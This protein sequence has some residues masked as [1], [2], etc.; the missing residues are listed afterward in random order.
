MPDPPASRPIWWR[1]LTEGVHDLSRLV[2]P[3]ECPGCGEWDVP[4]CDA[5][6]AVLDGPPVRCEEDVP[7][8]D[9]MDGLAPLPVWALASYAGPARGLVLG[10]KDRGRVDLTGLMVEAVH[11]VGAEVAP[12]LVGAVLGPGG[13]R[14]LVVPVPTTAA[15]R[16]RRGADLVRRLA[17]GLVDGLCQGGLDAGLAPVLARRRARDQVG[18]G[19][20]A[21]A[22]NSAGSVRV[23]APGNGP[24]RRLLPA[25]TGASCLLVDDVV[26]TGSTLAV[27]E[28]A[29]RRQGALVL[30]AIVI[31][32]TPAP[33]RAE[34]R[35][36][37]G[38]AG[39]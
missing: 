30:G 22:R 36:S 4:V 38:A 32:A 11:R 9:R 29:L 17:V 16:R 24:G 10:W 25:V 21:R 37:S 26:T 3:V 23:R 7:R 2:L 20:R 34:G 5:C 1:A 14:L 33:S 19:A 8:L 13:G 31:A 28:D 18:L 39:D 6:R 15:A 27:C 35:V 12:S